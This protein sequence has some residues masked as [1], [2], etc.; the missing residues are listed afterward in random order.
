VR[1]GGGD[2]SPHGVVVAFYTA[3]EEKKGE[4]GSHMARHLVDGEVR[5]RWVRYGL[6]ARRIRDRW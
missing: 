4:N 6:A 3:A 5:G 2:G 1:G